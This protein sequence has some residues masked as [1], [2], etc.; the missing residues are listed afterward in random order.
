ML[1]NS[2]FSWKI[3]IR[4]DIDIRI[5]LVAV[6][7]TAGKIVGGPF[8]KAGPL[9]GTGTYFSREKVSL[10]WG[11]LLLGVQKYMS[12][13][14]VCDVCNTEKLQI[15]RHIDDHSLSPSHFPNLPLSLSLSLFPLLQSPEYI[16]WSGANT[17]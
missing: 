5:F 10:I 12:R 16:K 8:I 1:K 6:I 3:K 4:P 2:D 15:L 13:K 9:I 17:H 11:G 7:K 14:R